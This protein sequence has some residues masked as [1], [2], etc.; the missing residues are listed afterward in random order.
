MEKEMRALYIEGSSEPTVA[1]SHACRSVRAGAK[2][3]QGYV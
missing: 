2:R 1:P 3:W